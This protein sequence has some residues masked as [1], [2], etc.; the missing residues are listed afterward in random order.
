MINQKCF[1]SLFGINNYHQIMSSNEASLIVKI[2]DLVISEGISFN[3]DQK[4]FK[5]VLYLS[6]NVSK[7]YNP[8]KINIISKYL[9]YVIHY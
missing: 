2:D 9:L 5:K 4:K 7:G 8:P 6:R 1:L 3:T